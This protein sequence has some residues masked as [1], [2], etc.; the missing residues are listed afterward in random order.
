MVTWLFSREVSRLLESRKYSV[1][2]FRELG[3]HQRQTVYLDPS[4]HSKEYGPS[5]QALYGL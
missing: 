1:V 5:C 3:G 4:C 2:Q